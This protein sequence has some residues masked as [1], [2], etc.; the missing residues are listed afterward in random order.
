MARDVMIMVAP[1]GARRGKADHPAIPL[2]PAEIVT[3]AVDSAAAGAAAIHL[4]VRDRDGNHSLDPD[5]YRAT[6]TPLRQALPELVIQV[7]TEAVGR[8]SPAEQMATVRALRPKAV[9]IALRE[10]V[11]DAASEADAAAFFAWV[12]ASG[13]APQFIL[14]T[15]EEVTRCLDLVRRGVIPFAEPFLL[16]VL[17]RYSV[18]QQSEPADLSPFAAALGNHRF[19]WAVC[20]FGRQEAACAVA[21]ARLGGHVRV[22]FENNLHLPDGTLAPDNAA[23]VAAVADQIRGEGCGIMDPRGAR[24]MMGIAAA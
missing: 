15:P 11:P 9:S 13:V 17:G 5:L 23:L 10:L 20:A 1:N 22:G 4:H 24:R 6:L 2:T 21:A 8:Y 16:F 18:G 14:Y 12:T 3:A 19:P 7:T